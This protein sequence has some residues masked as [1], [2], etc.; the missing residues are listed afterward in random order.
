GLSWPWRDAQ[1]SL[2]MVPALFDSFLLLM[3]VRFLFG[4][5]EAGGLPNNARGVA[6]WFSLSGR[7]LVPGGVLTSMQLGAAGSSILAGWLIAHVGWRISSAVF[8][9]I[10]VVWAALFHWWYR[11]DP[12][13]HVAVNGAEL[14]LIRTVGASPPGAH[15]H[16]PIP[17]RLVLSSP[18]VW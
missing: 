3:I 9:V 18:T 13:E 2:V 7:G 16:P 5:G 14:H 10:G 8:G 4:A 6:R 1:G 11:D 17:W 12:A 15:E